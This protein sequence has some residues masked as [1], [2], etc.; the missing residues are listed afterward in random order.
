MSE[1]K[2]E[3]YQAGTQNVMRISAAQLGLIDTMWISHT[4]AR[5]PSLLREAEKPQTFC[6]V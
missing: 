4:A 2:N 5:T 6:D 3:V 1:G